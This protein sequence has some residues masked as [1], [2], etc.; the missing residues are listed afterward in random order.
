MREKRVFVAGAFYHVPS[1]TNDK[2]RVLKSGAFY[3]DQVS[4]IMRNL[5]IGVITRPYL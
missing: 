3:E 4:D 2:I 1:R 5:R